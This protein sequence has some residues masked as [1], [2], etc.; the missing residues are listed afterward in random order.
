MVFSSGRSD[1]IVHRG[2]CS[3]DPPGFGQDR[4]GRY[5]ARGNGKKWLCLGDA[6]AFGWKG[7]ISNPWIAIVVPESID[8]LTHYQ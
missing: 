5:Q 4:G 6:R 2:F 7:G 1:E 3:Q 8:Q